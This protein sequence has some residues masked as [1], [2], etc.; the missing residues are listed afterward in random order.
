MTSHSDPYAAA[1]VTRM[2]RIL[3][4]EGIDPD[5]VTEEDVDRALFRAC[6]EQSAEQRAHMEWLCSMV[7]AIDAVGGL[8]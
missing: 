4:A 2:I 8:V 7:P 5:A 1:V 6:D 3:N